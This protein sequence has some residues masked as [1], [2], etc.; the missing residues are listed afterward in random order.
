MLL[1]SSVVIYL[2]WTVK[3]YDRNLQ[4]ALFFGFNGLAAA[5]VGSLGQ[6]AI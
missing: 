4:E 5:A 2:F 6:A 1:A 3:V